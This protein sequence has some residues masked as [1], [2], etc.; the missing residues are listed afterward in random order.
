MARGPARRWHESPAGTDPWEGLA[1]AYSD[2]DN[3]NRM[4]AAAHINPETAPKLVAVHVGVMH[5]H[6]PASLTDGPE[7]LLPV[8]APV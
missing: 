3:W 2:V 7:P 5:M 1:A 6:R 8:E 4:C